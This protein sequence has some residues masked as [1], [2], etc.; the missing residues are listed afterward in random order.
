MKINKIVIL[1]FGLTLITGQTSAMTMSTILSKDII[2]PGQTFDMYVFVDP[3]GI[4]I[5]GGQLNFAF[6]KS[7][8]RVNN[9]DKGPLFNQTINGMYL[10]KGI[11]NNSIGKV[12]DVFGLILG[13]Y[14]VSNSGVFIIISATAI[15]PT[16]ST[17][18]TFSNVKF[19]GPQG[20]I[21]PVNVI[22]GNV[23]IRLKGDLNNNGI[24]A[25]AGDQVLMKRASIGEIPAN[26]AYDL[27]NNGLFADAGDQ[28]LMKR[29]SIGEIIL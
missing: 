29:A 14:S 5:A 23:N 25:D 15:G 11:I 10:N 20:N 2:Y 18:I 8:I 22:N 28:V 26:S 19:N 12:S 21:V 9:I 4:E 13:P 17:L 7:L 24:P 1:V 16:G 6:D 3:Q 27:N